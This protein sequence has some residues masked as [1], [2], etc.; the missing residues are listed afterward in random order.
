M[1]WKLYNER[2]GEEYK[3]PESVQTLSIGRCSDNDIVVGSNGGSDLGL[4]ELS[5]RKKILRS[6][7][8][9]HA[10]ISQ[11]NQG[12][13]KIRDCESTNGTCVNGKRISDWTVL[14]SGDNI[15]FGL[16]SFK[17]RGEQNDET[18]VNGLEESVKQ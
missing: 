7:S 12:I 2:I 14:G 17:V 5:I 3:I 6:V 9:Y 13:L 1:T 18:K 15:F 11:D 4:E 16:Y 10:E 8:K